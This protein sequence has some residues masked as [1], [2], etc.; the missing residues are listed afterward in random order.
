M[1]DFEIIF[2]GTSGSVPT[3]D[4]SLPSIALRRKG[5]IILF[6]CG[7]GTQRQIINAKIGFKRR[8][9]IFITHM[10][11]DHLF[12][13]PGLLQTMSLM[14]RRD[15]LKIYGPKGISAFIKALE[16]TAYLHLPFRL[17]V[18]DIEAGGVVCEEEEY[19]IHACP[20]RHSVPGFAYAF[21]EKPRPG[22]FYPEKALALGVPKGSLWSQ[23]QMGKCVKLPDGRVIEPRMV[24]GPPRP[25]RKVVYS[26]DTRPLK[27][28]IELASGADVLIHEA[29]LGD[30]LKE[31]A[32]VEGHSTPSEAA[33]VALKAGVKMLILTHLSARYRDVT[34]IL[35][36]ALQ[37]FP[38]VQ[39]AY[40]LM[41]I[42]VPLKE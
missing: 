20:T 31:R 2:L 24:L 9:K 15:T 11:G 29:T 25:G 26:G 27:E 35:N 22:R 1:S 21:I 3:T 19:E 30:E 8:M 17:E 36:Q 14:D 23:L 13:L 34:P 39:V 5:E 38:N 33:E 7:E 18:H 42:K 37:V 4:R 41:R 28:M 32:E 6:D 12:G 40:D 10:H 16:L